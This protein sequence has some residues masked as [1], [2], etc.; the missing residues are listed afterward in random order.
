MNINVFDDRV[1]P[2]S[3]WGRES[4]IINTISLDN[5]SNSPLKK[6]TQLQNVLD[7][8]VSDKKLWTSENHKNDRA[9]EMA[10]AMIQ[11]VLHVFHAMT[12]WGMGSAGPSAHQEH[13]AG[14]RVT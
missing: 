4:Y 5:F 10:V 6:N 9:R 7:P 11:G 2:T 14:L 13:V 3:C 1:C 12:P 8:R